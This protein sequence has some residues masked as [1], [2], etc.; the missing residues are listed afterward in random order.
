MSGATDKSKVDDEHPRDSLET[1]T[2]TNPKMDDTPKMDD[3]RSAF[4]IVQSIAT[5]IKKLNFDVP[6][7]ASSTSSRTSLNSARVG[8]KSSDG[9]PQTPSSLSHKISSSSSKISSLGRYAARPKLV[10]R[11][12]SAS[13]SASD[14]VI[15]E[16]T[17]FIQGVAREIH[18]D[19]T[20]LTVFMSSTEI[21]GLAQEFLNDS[22]QDRS[23]EKFN[24]TADSLFWNLQY[25][26]NGDE[27]EYQW[28]R[29]NPKKA[30]WEASDHLTR[31]ILLS[32]KS[33][34]RAYDSRWQTRDM[35]FEDKV[36]FYLSVL[37]CFAFRAIY[38]QS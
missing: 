24:Y 37:R 26:E 32:D 36:N 22:Y 28:S 25:I 21:Q 9:R 4:D 7:R 2:A 18:A 23:T 34:L 8:R 5:R 16:M 29:S 33:R 27:N 15:D 31:F 1:I 13:A 10:S 35:S 14:D 38:V 19:P 20:T 12:S 30:D 3:M 11:K 17:N 6:A